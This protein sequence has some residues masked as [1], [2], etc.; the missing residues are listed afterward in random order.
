MASMRG[1]M[2]AENSTVCRS[3]GVASRI[4]SMSSAKPMSSISSASSRTTIRTASR[5]NVRRRMWSMAR[6]GVATTTWTP[7]RSAP[8]WRPIGWPP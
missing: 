2:V 7:S 3:A 8:S 4:D 6:P 5:R 1:G